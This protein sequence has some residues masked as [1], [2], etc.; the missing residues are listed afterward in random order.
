MGYKKGKYNYSTYPHKGNTYRSKYELNIAKDLYEKKVRFKY[1]WTELLYQVAVTGMECKECS[2]KKI[3][4]KSIYIPDFLIVRTGV[5]VEAKGKF[6]PK[7]RKKMLAV[8]ERHPDLDIRMLFYSNN[9]ITTSHKNRYS[10]WCESNNIKYAV[11][12][13]IPDDWLVKQTKGN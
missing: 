9:W 3:T 4:R 5:V 10:D 11:S 7:D 13:T 2:S 12:R 8:I 1:E 6:T